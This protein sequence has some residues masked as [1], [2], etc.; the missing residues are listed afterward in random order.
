MA[1]VRWR[2]NSA[3]LLA[4]VYENGRSKQITLASLPEL[5]ASDLTRMRVAEKFPGVKVD[6]L[7]VDRA[8]AQGPPPGAL[9]QD[10]PPEYLDYAAIE[11]YLRQWAKDAEEANMTGEAI[12]LR[13]AAG[14]LTEW[15]A[16][17]YFDNERESKK[18]K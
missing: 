5:Y 10:I 14:V 13:L 4:T 2:G 15:R 16:R 17:F 1:F 11:H 12:K 18:L 3:Q 7:A 9:K 6:W 8:L